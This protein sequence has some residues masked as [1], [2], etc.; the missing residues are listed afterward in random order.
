MKSL[1]VKIAYLGDD[2]KIIGRN[3]EFYSYF[4]KAG[5]LYENVDELV[6]T[7]QKHE[8]LDF[9]KMGHH[10]NEF[11]AYLFKKITGEYFYNIVWVRDDTFNDKKCLAVRI[12]DISHAYEFFKE[13]SSAEKRLCSALS[14]TNE[15]LFMY[16]KS[17]NIFTLHNFMQNQRT[18]VAEQDLDS[19]VAQMISEGLIEK[20]D[21]AE[22]KSKIKELKNCDE[23]FSFSVTSSLRFNHSISEK[24][25]FEANRLDDDGEIFMMGGLCQKFLSSN[26]KN[27]TNFSE[28]SNSIRLRGRTTKRRFLILPKS[29]LPLERE[30]MRFSQSLTSTILSL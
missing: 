6:A 16:Q 21:E 11:R 28:K 25:V 17:T 2:F 30:K 20:T 15:Y 5:F 10:D 9:V 3:K 12:T 23:N 1:D 4:E 27:R 19:W 13:A 14:I 22:F 24:L 26:P 7:D 29:D 8:F 18:V